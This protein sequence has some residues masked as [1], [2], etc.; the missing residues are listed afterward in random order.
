MSGGD[1]QPRQ[2]LTPNPESE[3]AREAGGL[4]APSEWRGAYLAATFTAVTSMPFM[5]AFVA[6]VPVTSTCWDIMVLHWL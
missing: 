4:R 2:G 5:P 1:F 6:T 3:T